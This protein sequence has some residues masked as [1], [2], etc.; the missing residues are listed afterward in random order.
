MQG[1]LEFIIIII[2]SISQAVAA[3][4]IKSSES[5]PQSKHTVSDHRITFQSLPENFEY[6]GVRS[7]LRDFKGYMWF[8]TEDGLIRFDGIQLYHYEH[9]EDDSS[10]LSN[11]EV[12]T[13]LE[14]TKGN[15]WIGTSKGLNLYNREKDCFIDA[16]ILAPQLLRLSE[17]YISDLFFD[18]KSQLWVATYGDGFHIVNPEN[19]SLEHF[20]YNPQDPENSI[21]TNV[22][23][24]AIRNEKV[25]L[26][27]ENGLCL[28]EQDDTSYRYFRNV[29]SN[30]ASL[31][32]NNVVSLTFDS[33]GELWIGTR[34]GGINRLIEQNDEYRFRR[35]I[36]DGKEGSLSNNVVLSIAEDIRGNIWFGTE[37]G[38]LNLFKRDK[39][40]FDVFRVEEGYNQSLTS[41][42]IWSLYSD[43]EDRIWIGTA[44]KGI[45]VIDEMYNKFDSYQKNPVKIQTSLPHSDVRSFAEDDNGN[46]WIGTDGG[47]VCLFDTKTREFIRQIRNT[48]SRQL[49]ENNA[50]QSVLFDHKKNLWIGMWG[51]GIDRFNVQ[52]NRSKHYSLITEEGI[53]IRNVRVLYKDSRNNI[54]A[55]SAGKGLFKYNEKRDHFEPAKCSTSADVLNSRLF[56]SCMLEDSEGNYWIGTL[57]GLILATYNNDRY[58]T[59]E[60]IIPDNRSNSMGRQKLHVIYEDTKGR[61]WAGTS[62]HG[63]SLIDRK[64]NKISVF[65][66]KDGLLSNTICGILEDDEGYLWVTSNR[67]MTRF[68]CDSMSFTY[69]TREDG[70]N[71]NEFYVNSCLRST[72]GQFFVG[73]ENG[74]NVFNPGSIWKNEVIPPIELSGLKIDNIPARIGINGSPLKKNIAESD[75]IK[76]THKQSSFTIE[77]IALNYTHPKKNRFIYKLE[78]LD[79]NWINAGNNRSVSYTSIKPGKY[80]FLV[81]GSN[82]DGIWN[83]EPRRLIIRILPPF[84]KTWWAYLFYLFFISGFSLLVFKVRQERIAIKNQLL[85]EKMAKEN[86][87]EMNER[88][89][90]F[91]TNISHEF[92]TPLSLIIGPLENLINSTEAGIKDQLRIMQRNASRLLHLTNNLMNFR[93]FEVDGVKLSVQEGDILTCLKDISNYFSI[94]IRRRK[95]IL[96]IES[97]ESEIM[98]WF[99]AEKLETILLNLLSNAIKFTSDGG[100]IKIQIN[101]HDPASTVK[102]FDENIIEGYTRYRHLELKVIDYGIGISNEDLPHIFDKFYQAKNSGK[103]KQTGTGIGLSLTRGLTE[104]HHG[105]IWVQS[106]PERETSFTVLIPIDREAYAD[107]EVVVQPGDEIEKNIVKADFGSTPIESTEVLSSDE[108]VKNLKSLSLK[109]TTNFDCFW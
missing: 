7:I 2:L 77:F 35:Y 20:S 69:F 28:F 55:G 85:L 82:N 62:D 83:P 98:G 18:E 78:G 19:G 11:N 37:N 108:S 50:V 47:G 91:F 67:G 103:S 58:L 101:C 92:R 99:D 68:H 109:T 90:E 97:N 89:I 96:N 45:N 14:D 27:T 3:T 105:H 42:S 57:T 38:G 33:L 30:P 10:S 6:N 12:N 93:K 32:N 29:P 95:L 26:G 104:I 51:G 9:A 8:G 86:E 16:G 75:E 94:R 64:N 79:E 53:E 76:L 65:R 102:K 44:N 80:V 36:S 74:F 87:H 15:L 17:N 63:L 41:N 48:E 59:C 22:T 25:W 23:R 54:W 21:S 107:H 52:T 61:I 84:W 31:S 71:S 13:L 1:R 73:G 43:M 88:N 100:L 72:T 81:K 106:I 49:L 66:K 46:I 5:R 56:I 24:I 40:W 70:L 4:P 60:D 39:E 34:G